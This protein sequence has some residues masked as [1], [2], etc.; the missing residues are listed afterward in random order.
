MEKVQAIPYRLPDGSGGFK[1]DVTLW[2][3]E[4]KHRI[5]KRG[6][7]TARA[8]VQWGERELSRLHLGLPGETR[9]RRP[10]ESG[11]DPRT[12]TVAAVFERCVEYWRAA[13][14]K[15]ESTLTHNRA[16]F[17]RTLAVLIGEKPFSALTSKDVL[18]VLQLDQGLADPKS[19]QLLASM[20]RDAGRVGAVAPAVECVPPRPKCNPRLVFLTPEEIARIRAVLCPSW[21]PAFLF[22]IA[23]G[24]R[25]GELLGLQ[26]TDLDLVNRTATI[27]HSLVTAAA[28]RFWHPPKNGKARVLPLSG[29]AIQALE[30]QAA[31]FPP[32]TN[33][34]DLE[35]GRVFRQT[36]V[37]FYAALKRAAKAAGVDKNISPHALR[38][39]FASL[40]VQGGVQLQRVSA[41]LGH[42]SLAMTM[43]YSHLRPDQ[44][45]E[46]V[47]QLSEIV[48]AA[49]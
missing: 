26:W 4:A 49:L 1:V 31:A 3:G 33:P 32:V 6:F 28:K 24:V 2:I 42:S 12:W 23:T 44:L 9:R 22:C 46:S 29:L 47:D 15:R 41:L 35:A 13:G 48:S 21:R 37:A 7:P 45:Q 39:T 25:V 43:R 20:I 36:S 38:H 16:T 19:S 18:H 17:K 14:R 34:A 10:A 11:E 30:E 40:Q 5:R 8:A 27:R